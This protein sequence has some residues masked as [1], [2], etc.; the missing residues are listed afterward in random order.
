MG[1]LRGFVSAYSQ[2]DLT[3]TMQRLR[4][5][6]AQA[7]TSRRGNSAAILLST[8]SFKVRALARR[9]AA[10]SLPCLS[11]LPDSFWQREKA[12]N[13]TAARSIVKDWQ[14]I[15]SAPEGRIL[16][17]LIASSLSPD[18]SGRLRSRFGV[19]TS[20][21]GIPARFHAAPLSRIGWMFGR[22]ANEPRLASVVRSNACSHLKAIVDG[23]P[24]PT[25]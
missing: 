25:S 7:H 2:N 4:L 17:V 13:K 6:A 14:P 3:G 5:P 19:E 23:W 18:R 11:G 1:V 16:Q 10:R 22:R 12:L 15:K 20:G 21:S 9:F 8:S 24:I